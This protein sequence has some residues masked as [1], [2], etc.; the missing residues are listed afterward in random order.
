MSYASAKQRYA[1]TTKTEAFDGPNSHNC[2]ANGCPM[3]GSISTTGTTWV[4]AYHHQALPTDWPRVTEALRDCENIRVAINEVMKIDMI[5][6]GAETNGYPPKW[7]EFAALFDNYPELQPT[8]HEKIR[9]T[10][11]EYRLRNELAIRAGLAK[12]KS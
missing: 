6:W 4:C 3:A 2:H 1:E 7:Q 10:K 12:R 9:K 8:E 5:S 11:Y